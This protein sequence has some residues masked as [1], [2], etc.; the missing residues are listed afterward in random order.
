MK[1]YRKIILPLCATLFVPVVSAQSVDADTVFTRDIDIVR[2]YTPKIKDAGK[3]NTLPKPE[4][5]EQPSK[6]EVNYDSWTTPLE[7]AQF[8]LRQLPA[9][10]IKKIRQQQY[11]REGYARIGAG[12]YTS[13]LGD[14]YAPIVRKND[15]LFDVFYNHLS[16]F[17]K[18]KLDNDEKVRA[19]NMTNSLALGFEKNF[20]P[21]QFSLDASYARNDF[22]YYGLDS[23]KNDVLYGDEEN[24]VVGVDLRPR[25]NRDAHNF[26][27]FSAGI[28]SN[29]RVAAIDYYA[30]AGYD[31]TKTY[32]GLSEHWMNISGG[33]NRSRDRYD[34]G[35]DF[36]FEGVV[37]NSPAANGPF[38]SNMPEEQFDSYGILRVAPFYRIKG[39]TWH[40]K[41]GFKGAFTFNREPSVAFSPDVDAKVAL[42]RDIFYFYA[43]VTGDLKNNTM[44]R[45]FEENRYFRPD[46]QVENT[47]VP[48]DASIGFKTKIYND[49]I[50]NVSAGYKM[51]QDD[52]FFVN[53]A[54]T[55]N[56]FYAYDNTFSFV[57]D[58]VNLL[59]AGAAL[60]YNW[61][62]R[63]EVMLEGNYYHWALDEQAKAW[64]RP[65]WKI[66]L[67]ATY[68]VNDDIRL[69]L[70][71][72][73]YGA[74]YAKGADEKAVK[75]DPVFD[76][77]LEGVYELNSWLSFYAKLNNILAQNYHIWYGYNSQR[78]NFMAGMVLSF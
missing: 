8:D 38:F 68:R 5:S 62:K 17:G 21:L 12:N 33:L 9:A 46:C 26:F 20:V 11:L 64:H 43:N 45:V 36:K 42:V 34:I 48:I 76:I 70:N 29:K 1:S 56:N 3:I 54:D 39:E 73:M 51:L 40:V 35:S 18:V 24:A 77:N 4:V 59:T 28:V 19:K 7:S 71:A 74:R 31:L 60:A 49:L 41:I 23:L 55:V 72:Y 22:N 75:L 66:D 14:F 47:Y 53:H 61:Q 6:V 78:F 65:D 10:T 69:A 15:M 58:N 13:F 32:T 25:H 37:Y 44:K 27:S 2:E 16:S 50:F 52:Y 67:S 57:K 30:N 63:V